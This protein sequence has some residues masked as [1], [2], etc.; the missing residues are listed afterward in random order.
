MSQ[1]KFSSIVL[2]IFLVVSRPA[3]ADV[4]LENICTV[5]GSSE[6]RLEGIGMVTGLNGTGDSGKNAVA[7]RAL[8]QFLTNMNS[9]A[10]SPKEL[11]GVKNVALVRVEAVI[12][13]RGIRYGQKID[14]HVSALMDAKSLRGGRLLTTPLEI[15]GLAKSQTVA[16]AAGGVMLE[17]KEHPTSGKIIAGASVL[18]D[19]V[20]KLVFNGYVTLMINSDTASFNTAA[21][22]ARRINDDFEL[23]TGQKIA[24]AVGQSAVRVKVPKTYEKVPV[25]FIANLMLV[26]LSQVNTEP[27]VVINEKEGVV[28]VTGEVEVSPTVIAI[29]G[30]KVDTSAGA[31]NQREVPFVPFNDRRTPTSSRNLKELIDAMK[32]LR[33]STADIIKILRMLKKSGKLHAKVVEI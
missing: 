22:I 3:S 25:E 13:R 6:I 29:D 9:A 4:R 12:P 1:L 19:F 28:I 16:K 24:R 8:G 20:P 31:G 11:K 5:H 2:V 17:S 10:V 33:V 26:R 27:R 14:V 30:L 21:E 15:S 32:D 7:M 18:M 23:E